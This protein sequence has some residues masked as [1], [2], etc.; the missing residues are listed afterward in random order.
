[1]NT[2]LPPADSLP[3]PIRRYNRAAV[4]AQRVEWVPDRW[5]NAF[6][7]HEEAH[8][9][10]RAHSDGGA[11]DLFL[12]AMAWGYRPK[13]YG[14]SRTKAI[15]D[16][17]FAEEKI[18]AIV[19][20]TRREGAAAGWSALLSTHKIRGLNMSFGTKLLYFAGYT[21]EHRPRPLILDERVRATLQKVAPAT[22]PATGLVLKADYLRYLDLAE[23][24]AS[25]PTWLQ[26]PDVV[27]FALFDQ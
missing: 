22:V 17:E 24:W 3:E 23:Q 26:E 25:E 14:P 1:M 6:S 8:A 21:T 19:E 16:E 11:V 2:P 20:A 10:L 18:E 13:D 4:E 9:A 15:L 27:E 5:L 7:G 12:M